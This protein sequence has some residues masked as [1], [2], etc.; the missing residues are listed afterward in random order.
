[1]LA[2]ANPR[3]PFYFA[4]ERAPILQRS[5]MFTLLAT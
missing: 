1:M 3:L 4:F 2:I 5:T